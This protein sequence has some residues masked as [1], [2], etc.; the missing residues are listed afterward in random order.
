MGAADV[1]H[2][3][4]AMG[5]RDIS[6]TLRR[7]TPEWPGD[8]PYDCRW[9]ARVSE[10]SS[11]N[12]SAI[13][14]SPHVGTHAD[15][16]LHVRDGTLGADTLPLD[17]FVGAVFVADVRGVQGLIELP[18]LQLPDSLR[19]ERLL[20]VTG[21]SIADGAFP[22]AWPVLSGECLRGLLAQGLRLVGTDAPSV[23]L[24]ESK[25]LANHHTIFDGGAFILENVDLR[26]VTPGS[27]EL[28]SLPI[29]L[30][31]LDAAPVRAALRVRDDG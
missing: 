14:G 6:V 13:S 21:Q 23:D 4:N 2:P 25:A 18:D 11:V 22:E 9:T 28:L 31:G 20:I 8:A 1:R 29:K 27:Y 24:R 19:V 17:A 12:V 7:G 15:A 10:G 26:G 3:P 30:E 16:P 5:L